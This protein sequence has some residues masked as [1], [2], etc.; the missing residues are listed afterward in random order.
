MH[1]LA[2]DG[3]FCALIPLENCTYFHML[4]ALYLIIV[5]CRLNL[6]RVKT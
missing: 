3:P 6:L 4:Q 5:R 1:P 2:T